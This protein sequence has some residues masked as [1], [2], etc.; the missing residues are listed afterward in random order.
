MR[1]HTDTCARQGGTGKLYHMGELNNK[2]IVLGITGGI[3]A[4]KS[5]ELT[6]GL[7]AAGAAVRVIMTRAAT[8]FI[9]PLT[10]QAVSGNPVHL[11]ML[12]GVADTDPAQAE[13]Q[14]DAMDHIALARWADAVLV[15]PASA[16]FL[17][18]LA[19]GRADDLL[20][21]V[22]LASTAP[23]AVAPAM[24]QQ[25]WLNTA[26]QANVKTIK[27]NG[28]K[29]FGPAE[30]A[31]AC[32]ETGPGRML[33]PGELVALTAGLFATGLLS[34]VRVVVTAGPTW[35]A[36][37]PVRGMTNRSSGKMGYAVAEA[38]AE[39]G[40]SVL[41]VSGPTNL[42]DPDRVHTVR[43]TSAQEMFDA[44][45]AHI[46][47]ADIFIGV[48]AVADY[49]PADFNADK[50]KKDRDTLNLELV[51]NPDILASVASLDGAPFTVG[52]AAETKDL[53][54]HARKKLQDKHLDLIA[55][56][57]VGLEGRGFEAEDNSLLLIDRSGTVELPTQHKSR[58]ARSLIQH[59]AKRYDEKDSAKNSRQA[60]WQ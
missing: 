10:L 41:L 40:G 19:Q 1:R 4:Y 11:H 26:T 51:K 24:N 32:G 57:L 38:A 21:T 35:E 47:E 59:I 27:I 5:A 55:A 20:T 46:R 54:R 34:N 58:L 13:S 8:E 14:G 56:N 49:R 15:A 39:A 29:T 7:R 18:R 23:L 48:A 6:R 31:Q 17:A 25:M 37:D 33:E 30:G 52:F 36:I 12:A 9:T 2:R 43:V 42:P 50:I 28:V 45:H 16:D 3:A 60:H 44:V 22:C 53:E